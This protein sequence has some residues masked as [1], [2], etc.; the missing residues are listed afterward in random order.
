MRSFNGKNKYYLILMAVI[1]SFIF[2]TQATEIIY[3]AH[4]AKGDDFLDKGDFQKAKMKYEKAIRI[5]P[6]LYNA[7]NKL[8]SLY[9]YELEE[10]QK[11][12]EMY[13]KG[14]EYAPD[15]YGLNLNIMNAYFDEED[16]ERAQFYYMKL[17]YK[18][19]KTY[20][21]FP[22]EALKKMFK[23]VEESDIMNF[24]YK[25]LLVNPADVSLH[26]ELA[27]IY[28][29]K[30][31]YEKWEIE[32]KKILQYASFEEIKA[33]YYFDLGSIYYHYGQFEASL[34]Q[35][36]LSKEAGFPVP[37]EIFDNVRSKIKNN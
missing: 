17:S 20:H 14:L 37:Q 2:C 36:Q 10:I 6:R 26:E 13:L 8:G 1:A 12:I 22:K 34:E 3:F 7:Y 25:Y 4:I 32:V 5:K 23:D 31:D 18:S 9:H 19:D 11:A 16:F 33:P 29:N 27:E 28:K 24:C 21:S 15:D 35:F 30:L